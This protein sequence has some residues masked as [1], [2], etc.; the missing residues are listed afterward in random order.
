MDKVSERLILEYEVRDS[1]F[2]LSLIPCVVCVKCGRV[3]DLLSKDY[4]LFCLLFSVIV[5]A[6]CN[7]VGI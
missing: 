3:F 2:F 1:I 4:L 5:I 7:V 6:S